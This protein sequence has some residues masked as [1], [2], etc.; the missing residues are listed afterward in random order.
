MWR[1]LR[2]R[3]DLPGAR[4]G[5]ANHFHKDPGS[6]H[7]CATQ[8]RPRSTVS[9]LCG[10]SC[11]C[12]RLNNL[13]PLYPF[14]EKAVR[15][16]VLFYGIDSQGTHAGEQRNSVCAA[17][18]IFTGRLSLREADSD[19]LLLEFS[20]QTGGW[21]SR[22]SPFFKRGDYP[23][24]TTWGAYAPEDYPD[25]AFPALAEET[26]LGTERTGKLR[27]FRV[28]DPPGTGRTYLMLHFAERK[29]SEGCIS[30]TDV[31]AWGI[32][33]LEMDCLYRAG[34][35]SIPLRV[36]YCGEKPRG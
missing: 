4:R 15:I 7:L 16:E 19:R 25:T 8:S 30:T 17:G 6:F 5:S 23:S 12:A 22:Q 2:G 13:T 14:M 28:P 10:C 34:I 27:G 21:M 11:S 24:D 3:L 18:R 20:V 32:F 31:A 33:C 26:T 36:V 35:S 9:A 29:G 1:T